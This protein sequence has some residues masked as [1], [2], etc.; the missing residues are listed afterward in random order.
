MSGDDILIGEPLMGG[1]TVVTEWERSVASAA[2][3]SADVIGYGDSSGFAITVKTKDLGETDA[4][5]VTATGG[6]F[7]TI[8]QAGLYQK[9]A[10]A[11]KELFRYELT[12]SSDGEGDEKFAHFRMLA[13][14]WE[15]D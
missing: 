11:L 10:T 15:R 13:P 3:F 7:T 5:A 1:T 8:T 2:T 9:R 12:L 4:Q 6:T 14:C